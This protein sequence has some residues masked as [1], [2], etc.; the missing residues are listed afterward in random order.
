MAHTKYLVHHFM[1][2]HMHM[3]YPFYYRRFGFGRRLIWFGLGALGATWWHKYHTEGFVCAR[4]QQYIKEREE[5]EREFARS[6]HGH[7][8]TYPVPQPNPS[9]PTGYSSDPSQGSPQPWVGEHFDQNRLRELG[10]QATDALAD[11]SEAMLESAFSTLEIL[12]K[13]L[14]E[15]RAERDKLQ[16][17]TKPKKDVDV[18]KLV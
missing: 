4:R 11:A 10:A 2:P 5:R 12:K 18:E 9:Q 14:R 16:A 6:G 3:M 13:R 7:V 15:Q 8:T 17:E 1:N